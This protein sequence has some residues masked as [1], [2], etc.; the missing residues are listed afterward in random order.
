M[1]LKVHKIT[2]EESSKVKVDDSVF[3]IAIVEDVIYRAVVSEMT[4]SRSGTHSTKTRSEVRGGGRKPWRQKGRGVARAGTI[5]SPLWRSGGVTFGPKPKNYQY[6]L[7]KKMKRLARRSV[8]SQRAN[9]KEI[10]VIDEIQFDAP[11]TKN[12]LNVLKNLNIDQKKVVFLPE[13]IDK[14]VLL[15]TRNLPNVYVYSAESA[16]TYN[17]MNCDVLLFDKMGIKKINDSLKV[18]NK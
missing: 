10:M 8:L 4:N 18:A 16:S 7:P 13:K 2:G 15:S 14:N 11:N 12:F 6:N 3:K 5:R 17:M 9:D 1:Q